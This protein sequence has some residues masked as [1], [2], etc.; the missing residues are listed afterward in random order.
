MLKLAGFI[1]LIVA[2]VAAGQETSSIPTNAS[3]PFLVIVEGV[4]TNPVQKQC[5]FYCRL[6]KGLME[7]DYAIF[8]RQRDVPHFGHLARELVAQG[9][10]DVMRT[11]LKGRELSPY[12]YYTVSE[13]LAERLD[14]GAFELLLTNSSMNMPPPKGDEGTKQGKDLITG[15]GIPEYSALSLRH[16]LSAEVYQARAQS[17]LIEILR[18]HKRSGVRAFAAEALGYSKSPAVIKPLQ[19]AVADKAYVYCVQC[20]DDYVGQ[21]AQHALERIGKNP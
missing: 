15:E 20:G 21:Y 6:S 12:N 14:A 7:E 11:L 16:Y 5:D 18:N 10:L 13:L 3:R 4:R 8:T 2:A 17:H 9:N 19:E 1:C